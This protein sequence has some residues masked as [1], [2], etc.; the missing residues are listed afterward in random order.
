MKRF[1]KGLTI[2]IIGALLMAVV[3]MPDSVKSKLP[4]DPVSTWAK[5][6]KITLGLD[7]QG[8]TQLDY[9]IDLRK[10]EERNADDDESNN[11]VVRDIV[12][13]VRAT[14]ERRVNGLGVSEPNIYTSDVAG[15]KHVIVEL[16][17]IKDVEEA[18]AI[19]GKTIQLEFKEPKTEEDPD[20][21]GKIE[22][23]AS[24]T[25]KKAL[26]DPD[27]F[28]TV[29]QN[30]QTSD[31]KILY[32]GAEEGWESELA[33]KQ[34][35]ILPT[36]EA[37]QVYGK[38][39]ENS[40]DFIVTPDRQIKERK[41]FLIL[42]LD[43]KEL[44]DKTE[45]TDGEVRASHILIAYEGA[46][47]AAESVTRTK[48]EASA[49]VRKILTEVQADPDNFGTLAEKYS[50][51]PTAAGKGGDLNFFGKGTMTPEFES[52]AFA[53]EVGAISDVVETPFGF[54]I[55]K[56]TDKKEPVET[57]VKENYYTYS[58]ILYDTTPDPW[59]STGLDGSHF[60]SASVTYDQIGAPQVA[61]QFD[62][63]GAN[64]FEELTD[65][66]VNQ[67]LAIFVG[68][69]LISAPRVNQK[70]IGGQ[71][72]ITGIGSLQTALQLANDLNTGAIDAPIILSGQYTISASLGENALQMSLYAGLIGLIVLALFM[73][74]YYRLLGIFAVLA[75]LIYSVIVIFILK[76]TGIVM[77]LAGIAGIILSIGMAVDANILIF[78]RTKEELAEGQS[79]IAAITTGFERAW[80][81]I[82]DSNVSSLITCVILWFFGNSIIRGFALMLALGIVVSMFT[83]INVTRAFLKTLN[84]TNTS[85]NRFLLGAKKL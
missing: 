50:D 31:E 3:A 8:G 12:E 59:K 81:S 33:V 63:E 20:A 21:L 7:L 2:I 70:I 28:E 76:T 32:K 85:K 67:Q 66:L 13:G 45:K 82:R 41:G 9:R 37:G 19:V 60:K 52:A 55:I 1:S 46:E 83:A 57:T 72:V 49:E 71:A 39:V 48:E 5:N 73:I 64:L 42:K 78:E 74:L 26:A 35:E 4:S 18:K 22:A 61:I 65:R 77:T 58:E 36:M 47:R 15:E 53:L 11:V 23:E 75:L 43:A 80:S 29:G 25:L 30:V 38:L 24:E 79:Y 34:K 6:Q 56:V 51:D 27:K 10:I 40:G 62:D 84:G 14:L 69:E 54:H 16:A 68:G 17:G 44:R